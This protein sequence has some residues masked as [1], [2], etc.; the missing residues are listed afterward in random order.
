MHPRMGT[1]TRRPDLPRVLYS[2]FV[3]A[4]ESLRRVGRSDMAAVLEDSV[5]ISKVGLD[6]L[7]IKKAGSQVG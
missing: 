1:D 6:S 3:A 5:L 4:R 7:W 2:A